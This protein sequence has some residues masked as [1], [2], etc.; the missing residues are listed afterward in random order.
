M[1]PKDCR[2]LPLTLP[3]HQW[4]PWYTLRSLC[5]SHHSYANNAIWVGFQR[6]LFPK[7]LLWPISP[8]LWHVFDLLNSYTLPY[9][10]HQKRKK[11]FDNKLSKGFCIAV[12]GRVDSNSIKRVIEK[13]KM[14]PLFQLC[15]LMSDTTA[16]TCH[17]PV[18]S[19]LWGSSVSLESQ[20]MEH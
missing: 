16:S 19:A 18:I 10:Q 4:A 5:V 20:Y 1:W 3:M 17:H 8:S 14:D 11:T 2:V 15:A 7:G 13:R 12:C 9:Q 6:Y